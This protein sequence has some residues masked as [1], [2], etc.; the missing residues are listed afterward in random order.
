M[1]RYICIHGHFYQPPRENAWLESVEIQD[2]AYPYHDWNEK[3]TEECYA[4]NAAS[5]IFDEQGRIVQIV[6]NSPGS[7]TILARPSWPA[8]PGHFRPWRGSPHESAGIE[9]RQLAM[10]TYA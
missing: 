8:D 6:N 7:A 3:I 10:A 9:D 4:A 2:S 5:R 1:E